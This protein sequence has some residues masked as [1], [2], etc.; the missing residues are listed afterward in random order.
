MG[1]FDL[2][3]NLL[4]SN[5]KVQQSSGAASSSPTPVTTQEQPAA[6]QAPAAGTQQEQQVTQ[7]TPEQQQL[8]QIMEVT[9]PVM[10][11]KETKVSDDKRVQQLQEHSR[12]IT[13][14]GAQLTANIEK[15][16][17]GQYQAS[18]NLMNASELF[19]LAQLEHTS[20]VD[21]RIN[22][23]QNMYRE[24]LSTLNEAI[25]TDLK[26][27]KEAQDLQNSGN[28][29]KWI[30]GRVKEEFNN[31]TLK[32]N[33][34]F[35]SNVEAQQTADFNNNLA[36]RQI[37]TARTID[38][39]K[40]QIIAKTMFD[41]ISSRVEINAKQ[42]DF[43]AKQ[44]DLGH[45]E[46]ADLY[47]S[48]QIDMQKQQLSIQG[49]YLKIAQAQDARAVK[50]WNNKTLDKEQA[51]KAGKDTIAQMRA[52]MPNGVEFTD[53]QLMNAWTD[54]NNVANAPVIRFIQQF[55]GTQVGDM[56]TAAGAA[57]ANTYAEVASWG[58][59]A[60]GS[61]SARFLKN[62]Q[63][64]VAADPAVQ[65][66]ANSILNG[67]DQSR[68]M[69]YEQE[70]QR[71]VKDKMSNA[72]ELINDNKVTVPTAESFAQSNKQMYSYTKKAEEALRK[73]TTTI[74][75]NSTSNTAY[76]DEIVKAATE[77]NVP[78]QD[79]ANQV[80]GY[81]KQ[82]AAEHFR[83]KLIPANMSNFKVNVADDYTGSLNS[84]TGT[85]NPQRR[86]VDLM[87]PRTVYN[88]LEASRKRQRTQ[89]E[90]Q[91]QQQQ[92]NIQQTN[93]NYGINLNRGNMS[94]NIKEY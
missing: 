15:E 90:L 43:L 49:A 54:P 40:K 20:V 59:A 12:I 13:N 80:S 19:A 75:G 2:F 36:E 8:S 35:K 84:F 76:I 55:Q 21:S 6:Q 56:A 82:V 39:A 74:T 27:R 83:R 23:S 42:L 73:V 17:A 88:L 50:E 7:L 57:G 60:I 14:S 79:M 61:E 66:R 22:E 41:K 26:D 64:E 28:P 51:I 87:D 32:E 71:R 92:I 85:F 91:A 11:Q 47:Q 52:A 31:D 68:A 93:S 81:Y 62:I 10:V 18:D 72:Q 3:A 65:Q 58:T 16:L 33:M 67:S 69:V 38:A 29:L 30:W 94:V 24:Q 77:N 78:L 25:N 34:N 45:K 9:V 86:A 48:M 53:A 46:M 89:A 63:N 4:G 44:F 1:F 5:A 37:N 70:F